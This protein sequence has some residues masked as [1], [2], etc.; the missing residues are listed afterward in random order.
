MFMTSPHIAVARIWLATTSNGVPVGT[1]IAWLS[2]NSNGC[3]LE[4]TRVAAVTNCALTQGPFAPGGGGSA[5]PT[6]NHGAAIVTV[7]WPLTITRGFGVVGCACPACEQSTLA[8]TWRTK[9]G[10]VHLPTSRPARR[11]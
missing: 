3:P 10:I 9:P 5:Q 6:I 8:P 7:G 4:V 1:Q 11:C 2:N